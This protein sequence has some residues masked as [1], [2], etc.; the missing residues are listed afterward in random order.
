MPDGI[1]RIPEIAEPATP[2]SGKVYIY[3]DTADKHTKQKDDAGL[4]TDLTISGAD[5]DA[6]HD[7]V[8]SEISAITEK[9]TPVGADLILIEDSADSNAKKKI[10]I[11]NLPGSGSGGDQIATFEAN[12][13]TF[14]ASS[15]AAAT[16]R[17]E[18]PI[19]AFD[20]STDENIIFHGLISNDYSNAALTVHIDW[21]AATA[22]TGDVKWDVQFERLADGGTDIDADSFAT[23]QTS[24]DT[25]DGTSGIIT[26][27]SI[28]FTQVQADSIVAGDS[29]RLKVTRDANAAGDTLSGD[30]QIL[31]V[32]VKQ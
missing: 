31:R 5:S 19:I 29:F 26:R 6:I 9:G 12:M 10:Q 18:H 14:P 28:A 15:P 22:T 16:S 32:G 20:D 1:M 27:S 17:N 11:T 30:A 2:P 24:T 3:I 4:V 23:L 8:A 7:N 13:A 21:V 25:T